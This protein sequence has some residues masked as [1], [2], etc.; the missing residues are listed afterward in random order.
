MISSSKLKFGELVQQK[1]DKS[2]ASFCWAWGSLEV[3]LILQND[4]V[5]GAIREAHKFKYI[6]MVYMDLV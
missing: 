3:V 5:Q 4:T 6:K 1:G 2:A